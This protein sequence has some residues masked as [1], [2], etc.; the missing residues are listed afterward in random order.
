VVETT[1]ALD[2]GFE[3]P[4]FTFLSLDA[5]ATTGDLVE[6]VKELRSKIEALKNIL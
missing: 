6:P 2:M 5:R 3:M 4:F 1:S